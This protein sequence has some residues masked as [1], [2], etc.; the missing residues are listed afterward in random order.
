M[1][2]TEEIE[3]HENRLCGKDSVSSCRTYAN[4]PQPLKNCFYSF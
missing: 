4:H 1:K 2:K 3:I